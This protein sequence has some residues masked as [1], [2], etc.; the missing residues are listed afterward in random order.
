MTERLVEVRGGVRI[1]VRELGAGRPVLLIHG[2][3][4]SSEAWDR[5][6][7]VLAE[8]GHR[9]LAMDLRGHGGSD[10]PLDGYE[11]ESLAAD[12]ADVL[13]ASG[14]SSAAVV[15]WS[16]GGMVALRLASDHTALVERV[17][18]VASNGVAASRTPSFPF[19]VPADGP[20]NAILAAEHDDRIALR[21]SAVGDPFEEKPAPHVLDWLHRISL[22][23]PS[24]SAR[25]AMRTLLCTDQVDILDSVR[26]PVTQIIG[27]ADPALSVRGAR[28]LH[29]RLGTTLVELDTGHYP[30]L[31]AAD[32]FDAA[33][34]RAVGE[35]AT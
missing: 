12:A 5:Q 29:E 30:M 2:W 15:G 11:I 31:E 34:L 22:R 8:R 9:V 7:R 21:R 25:A 26:I 18:L 20:L 3:S 32:E 27:T 6:I 4:L 23:T 35:A 14:A 33:L 10:A 17:V 24:W 13:A 1:N 16:L 28:W 19:G